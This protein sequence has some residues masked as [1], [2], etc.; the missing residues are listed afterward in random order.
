MLRPEEV[1]TPGK[2]PINS[3]NVYVNRGEEQTNFQKTLRRG[4]I[5]II[6]GEYG[7]GKTSMAQYCCKDD[8]AE[9]RLVN[10]SNVE[11]MSI[12]DIKRHCLDIIDFEQIVSTSKK[13]G[14]SYKHSQSGSAGANA[15]AFS[16]KLS[17][18]RESTNSGEESEVRERLIQE[19]SNEKFID[20]CEASRVMLIVD[21]LHKM[22]DECRHQLAEFIKSYANKNCRDFRIALL[23]TSY[24]ASKLVDIDIGIDRIIC[25]IKLSSLTDEEA[26]LIIQKGMHDLQIT[27]NESVVNNLI[28]LSC[29]S[30]NML[31]FLCLET[32]DN[33]FDSDKRLVEICDIEKALRNYLEQKASRLY[34]RFKVAIETSGPIRYRTQILKAMSQI[35]DEFVETDEI[36]KR[37]AAL[38]DCDVATHQISTPLSALKSEEKGRIL[39]DVIGDDGKRVHGLTCFSDPAMKSFIR[40]CFATNE[41]FPD[42]E[43]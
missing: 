2:I 18:T 4:L 20:I 38:L 10:I 17:S 6:Y 26:E 22:N 21:E 42:L 41:L 1:F 37:V 30:P 12:E 40:T 25:E 31:Q 28:K 13:K 11:G 8:Q 27:V 29:G 15:G 16:A 9:G 33:V 24:D 19:P 32:A 23:G 5:P 36:A 3:T 34:R 43:I 35:E 39:Q 7:V 14:T